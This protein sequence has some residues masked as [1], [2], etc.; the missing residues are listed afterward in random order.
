MQLLTGYQNKKSRV[1]MCFSIKKISNTFSTN[2]RPILKF[3]NNYYYQ[4]FF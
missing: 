2:G 4:E 1:F 3:Y